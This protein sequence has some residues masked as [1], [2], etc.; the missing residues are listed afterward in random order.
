[1]VNNT[2]HSVT[3]DRHVAD[4]ISTDTRN[5]VVQAFPIIDEYQ[6]QLAVTESVDT[7]GKF[8][9]ELPQPSNPVPTLKSLFD[10]KV[11]KKS[12]PIDSTTY[13]IIQD[14]DTTAFKVGDD[15]VPRN[16]KKSK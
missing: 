3:L 14:A 4:Q 15:L 2:I 5:S 13:E 9:D 12:P 6:Q 1:M 10:K 7:F 8:L 11:P 16:S